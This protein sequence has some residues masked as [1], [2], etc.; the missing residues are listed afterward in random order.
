MKQKVKTALSH[1]NR[2]RLI[3]IT[4]LL[5]LVLSTTIIVWGRD[6]HNGQ[7]GS[8]GIAE[9]SGSKSEA[10]DSNTGKQAADKES[11]ALSQGR[12]QESPANPGRAA[13]SSIALRIQDAH[14]TE[15]EIYYTTDGAKTRGMKI[16][17][18]AANT[19]LKNC[20]LIDNIVL[21]DNALSIKSVN[22][23][24]L[25]SQDVLMEDGLHTVTVSCSDGGGISDTVKVRVA[26]RQ[27][28]LCAS[29][30]FLN[31]PIT[32]GSFE[33]LRDG[34]VGTW[35]GCVSTPWVPA[36]YVTMTFKADG[37]Y[38]AV[39]SESLDGQEM[40]AMYYGTEADDARKKYAVTD[41]EASQTGRGQ[42][43]I[44]FA[45]TNS[46]NRGDLRNIRLMGDKLSFE[47]FHRGQYGPLTFQLYRQ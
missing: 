37:T 5:L 42:I 7:D 1:D 31:S 46:V 11:K 14:N 45:D 34:M 19:N 36:Y 17:L 30:G 44:V 9:Q 41:Y 26:D 32:A 25:A 6:D 15:G 12:G 22:Y 8:V 38:S 24:P 4:V 35:R 10:S 39:S 28:K 2:A 27:P 40:N 13:R 18:L 43:D 20:K 16:E 3:M 29:F 47:F 33:Q 21:D 23:Q